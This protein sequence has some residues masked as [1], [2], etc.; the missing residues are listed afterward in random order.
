M[1]HSHVEFQQSR[2]CGRR[3]KRFFALSSLAAQSHP[4]TVGLWVRGPAETFL[5]GLLDKHSSSDLSLHQ[6]KVVMPLPTTPESNFTNSTVST[7]DLFSRFFCQLFSSQVFSPQSKT[8]L[9]KNYAAKG[10]VSLCT[11]SEHR[12]A[13]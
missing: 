6:S 11:V 1:Q 7:S 12:H 9:S 4:G 2:I 3:W 13:Y 8:N 10:Q 5:F